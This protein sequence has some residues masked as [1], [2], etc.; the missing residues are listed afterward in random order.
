MLYFGMDTVLRATC[1]NV[2]PCKVAINIGV[3][4]YSGLG[5]MVQVFICIGRKKHTETQY[6]ACRRSCC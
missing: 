1:D 6:D 2:C 3:N 5:T 4:V